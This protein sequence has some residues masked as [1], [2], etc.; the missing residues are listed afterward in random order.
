M[1]WG[2]CEYC[3]KLLATE[4]CSGCG[5]SFIDWGC[6]FGDDVIGAPRATSSGDLCCDDCLPELEESALES[7]EE[8]GCWEDEY[9]PHEDDWIEE[10]KEPGPSEE[11]AESAT[12]NSQNGNKT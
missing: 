4:S 7:E 3:G 6:Q 9:D 12:G 5:R 2:S 10:L 11:I 8:D 1:L